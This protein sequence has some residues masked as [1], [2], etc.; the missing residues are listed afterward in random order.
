M[1]NHA[2]EYCLTMEDLRKED[3]EIDQEKLEELSGYWFGTD[4]RDPRLSGPKD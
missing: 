2:D 4:I 3:G 1:E